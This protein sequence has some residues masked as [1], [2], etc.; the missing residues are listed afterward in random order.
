MMTPF[1]TLLA[2]A[3]SSGWAVT[4]RQ[5]PDC[6]PLWECQLTRPCET[7]S[8]GI[9]REVVFTSQHPSPESA[10][11]SALS[12]TDLPS[13]LEP[14][15]ITGSIPVDLFNLLNIKPAQPADPNLLPI[16]LITRRI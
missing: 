4:L 9:A 2:E 10:L 14:S 13:R 11:D 1:H 5:H 6:R 3:N 8:L 7:T 16:P 15:G 12:R